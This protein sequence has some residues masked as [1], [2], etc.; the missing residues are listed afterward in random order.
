[1]PSP[2]VAHDLTATLELF[3]GISFLLVI[4]EVQRLTGS[5]TDVSGV[6]GGEGLPS[7]GR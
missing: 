7:R 2:R 6:A 4:L 1:M 5:N 3:D